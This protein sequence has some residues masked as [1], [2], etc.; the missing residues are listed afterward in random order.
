[1]TTLSNLDAHLAYL[2]FDNL[3]KTVQDAILATRELNLRF[4]WVDALCMIQDSEEHKVQQ[5]SLLWKIFRNAYV[6][7]I[8]NCARTC[9]DGFLAEPRIRKRFEMPYCD[10]L[11]NVGTVSLTA[12]KPVIRDKPEIEWLQTRAWAHQELC[13]STRFISYD[14]S[15]IHWDCSNAGKILQ[16][17]AGWTENL[18]LF[19]GKELT[20][21]CDKL[22]SISSLAAYYS[23]SLQGS[24]YL[25]GVFSAESHHQLCWYGTTGKRLSRPQE[26]RA[27]SWSPMAVDGPIELWHCWKGN[28]KVT[29]FLVENDGECHADF[30]IL[31]SDV[32][33]LTDQ[34]PFGRVTSG[35]LQVRGRIM[36]LRKETLVGLSG[37]GN[38]LGGLQVPMSAAKVPGRVGVMYFD[39]V[40][41]FGTRIASADSIQSNHGPLNENTKLVALAICKKRVVK[42]R[43]D[44]ETNVTTYEVQHWDAGLIL[45]QLGNGD[46][47]RVGHFLCNKKDI[48]S[49]SFKPE[50]LRIV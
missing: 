25:A 5:T 37:I 14:S 38:L 8:A 50:V 13:F 39:T 27:P 48:F 9:N 40:N 36:R 33:V 16:G 7:I 2:D 26:W 43:T 42:A 34:A 3:S 28:N 22:P 19:S 4:L 41:A 32:Q 47:H 49:G 6:S 18:R 20:N 35:F 31:N 46:Y 15:G 1:M 30:E 23:S 17:I 24:K 11:G 45:A 12:V 44:S 29:P 10:D 21:A